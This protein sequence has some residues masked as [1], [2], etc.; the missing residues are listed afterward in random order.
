MSS[1]SLWW[2]KSWWALPCLVP[3]QMSCEKLKEGNRKTA[4][5]VQFR[6]LSKWSKKILY[7]NGYVIARMLSEEEYTGWKLK[8]YHILKLNKI[9]S[10]YHRHKIVMSAQST[11]LG[12]FF[13]TR[14]VSPRS[15]TPQLEGVLEKR[16]LN[17][18]ALLVSLLHEELCRAFLRR[19]FR[20]PSWWT[21]PS[22]GTFHHDIFKS[23]NKQLCGTFYVT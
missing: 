8:M 11:L 16:L 21:F 2:S 22:W 20:L 9:K 4:F 23:K 17:Y 6:S 3:V 18:T 7:I 5:Q 1:E 14:P 10:I 12:D 15:T 19:R 13:P